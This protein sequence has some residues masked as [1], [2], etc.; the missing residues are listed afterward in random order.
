MRF[1]VLRAQVAVG[2]TGTHICLRRNDTAMQKM[3]C[4][5]IMIQEWTKQGVTKPLV[6]G[7][8]TEDDPHQL[9]MW[10]ASGE[11]SG[12]FVCMAGR[13]RGAVMAEE[14]DETRG[15]GE[16]RR[17]RSGHEEFGWG[18]EGGMFGAGGEWRRRMRCTV[19]KRDDRRGKWEV[20]TMCGGGEEERAWRGWQPQE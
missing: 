10:E 18:G 19:L 13:E 5:G 8:Q 16:R 20:A 3:E 11:A 2:C 9:D 17:R 4:K 14:L 7:P 1:A 12:T 15:Q 6:T